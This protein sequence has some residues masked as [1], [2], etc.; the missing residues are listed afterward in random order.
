MKSGVS[1]FEF[2]SNYIYIYIYIYSV[3]SIN[4]LQFYYILL[5]VE[6]RGDS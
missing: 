5:G 6:F 2:Q 1:V 3:I 4:L